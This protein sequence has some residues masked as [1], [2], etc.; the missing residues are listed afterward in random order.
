MTAKLDQ[1]N[2]NLQIEVRFIRREV[3]QTPHG[4]FFLLID[5]DDN[6]YQFPAQVI[7]T[8]GLTPEARFVATAPLPFKASVRAS[9]VLHLNQLIAINIHECLPVKNKT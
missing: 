1:F 5:D 7:G 9:C 6:V 2:N 3:I 4:T 8:M